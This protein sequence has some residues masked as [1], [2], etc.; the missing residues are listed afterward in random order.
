M[1]DQWTFRLELSPVRNGSVSRHFMTRTVVR[2]DS[3]ST[4]FASHQSM[5]FCPMSFAFTL[6][7]LFCSRNAHH[8]FTASST[9]MPLFDTFPSTKSFSRFSN[10]LVLDCASDQLRVTFA[11]Q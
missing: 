1:T 4:P 10:S 6:F 8:S 3:M 11:A 7:S 2:A 9:D 5:S